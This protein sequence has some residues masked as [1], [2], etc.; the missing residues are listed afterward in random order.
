MKT[1]Y[2]PHP[3]RE[4]GTACLLSLIEAELVADGP[5]TRSELIRALARRKC[6]VTEPELSGAICDLI[7]TG[8]VIIPDALRHVQ[9][10]ARRDMRYAVRDRDPVTTAR[11]VAREQADN[12]RASR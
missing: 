1:T 8:K 3:K 4:K 9:K 6:Q 5:A 2:Q 11:I 7:S 10:A 12:A